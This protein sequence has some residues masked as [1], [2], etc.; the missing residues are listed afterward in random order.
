MSRTVAKRFTRRVATL[1]MGAIIVAGCSTSTVRP[2]RHCRITYH[3]QAEARGATA[4]CAARCEGDA[5][6]DCL[7]RCPGVEVTEGV[8]CEEDDPYSICYSNSGSAKAF[9]EQDRE[10]AARAAIAVLRGMTEAEDVN[11]ASRRTGP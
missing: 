8:S 11:E 1:T 7:R 5:A 6:M 9:G 10:N 2:T 3:A 4:S